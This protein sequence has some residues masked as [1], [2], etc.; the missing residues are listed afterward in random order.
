VNFL[1]PS[2]YLYGTCFDRGAEQGG[3]YN[4]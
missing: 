1:S 4:R 2:D 3:V